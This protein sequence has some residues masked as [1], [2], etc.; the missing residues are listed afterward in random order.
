[1]LRLKVLWGIFEKISSPYQLNTPQ[2]F[3]FN[4]K[5]SIKHIQPLVTSIWAMNNG[6]DEMWM[7]RSFLEI[8]LKR[9][10]CGVRWGKERNKKFNRN[11][12]NCHHKFHLIFSSFSFN[13]VLL[14]TEKQ[15][16]N[17]LIK[18]LVWKPRNIWLCIMDVV[19][20]GDVEEIMS[21]PNFMTFSTLYAHIHYCSG[22]WWKDRSGGK[23][24]HKN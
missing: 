24:T 22:K 1:M 9:W 8:I 3:N 15:R 19:A 2:S 11:N 5:L 14:T 21:K 18:D 16:N 13:C 17:F 12:K 10:I 20:A 6:L 4:F 23:R 7:E